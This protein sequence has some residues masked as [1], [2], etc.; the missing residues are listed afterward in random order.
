MKLYK[1]LIFIHKFINSSYLF[2]VYK[3]FFNKIFIKF[4]SKSLIKHIS[5]F[6]LKEINYVYDLKNASLAYGDFLITLMLIKIL[7]QKIKTNLIFINSEFR[8]DHYKNYGNIA[9]INKRLDELI[10]ISKF[11]IKGIKIK[12]IGFRDLELL[13]NKKHIY[14]CPEEIFNRDKIYIYSSTLINLLYKKNKNY[15]FTKKTFRKIK[16]KKKLPVK[17]IAL[18]LR[19]NYKNDKNRN[20]G[21]KELKEIIYFLKS[22]FQNI[23]IIIITDLRSYNLLKNKINFKNVEFSEKFKSSKKQNILND[24]KILINSSLYFSHSPSGISTFVEFSKIP[25]FIA[26]KNPVIQSV[27]SR[28]ITSHDYYFSKEKRMKWSTKFQ[29]FVK[30]NKNE[31]FKYSL[32]C[33]MINLPEKIKI[34]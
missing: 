19:Y 21:L 3:N 30:N 23:S 20:T 29:T 27:L 18:G 7:N 8:V 1:I 17:Y 31:I 26:A 28:E 14:F 12:K 9:N 15:L 22:K 4:K 32:I 33:G 16:L 10:Q 5:D 6:K 34:K 2:A 13:K 11:I 25:Y 24:A